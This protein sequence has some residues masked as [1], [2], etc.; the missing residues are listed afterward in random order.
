MKAVLHALLLPALPLFPQAAPSLPERLDAEFRVEVEKGKPKAAS[1]SDRL[2]AEF[3]LPIHLNLGEAVLV[4][5]NKSPAAPLALEISFA[6]ETT[7][8]VPAPP[9]RVTLAAG[10]PRAEHVVRI[11]GRPDGQYRTRIREIPAPGATAARPLVRTLIKQTLPEP[12]PPENPRDVRGTRLLF[13]DDWLLASRAGTVRRVHPP[14]LFPVVPWKNHPDLARFPRNTIS[15]FHVDADGA[16]NVRVTAARASRGN[17]MANAQTTRYWLKSADLR[18]WEPVK[19]PAPPHPGATFANSPLHLSAPPL[20][21]GAVCR[22]H[23]PALDGPP[24]IAQVRVYYTGLL[25]ETLD[26]AGFKVPGRRVVSVWDKTPGLRL[27]LKNPVTEIPSNKNGVP[28]KND[29]SSVND[30]FGRPLLSADGKTLRF[31]QTRRVPR[32]AP[33]RVHYD[34]L[35]SARIQVTWSSDDGIHWTPAAFAP[36]GPGDSPFLQHYDMRVWR[37]ENGALEMAYLQIYDARLQQISTELVCSRDGVLWRRVDP[38]N[39]FLK[40][41]APGEW[42]FGFSRPT[43]N[44][45]R[46]A[47]G[48]HYYETMHGVDALHFMALVAAPVAD[49]S[50][51]PDDIYRTRYGGRMAGPDGLP[52]SPI[53][54]WYGSWDALLNATRGERSTPALFRYR[55]DRWASLSPENRTA[56]VLTKPLSAPGQTLALN[57]LAAAGEIRVEVRDAGGSPLP[58]YS[59]PDAARFSGDATAAPLRWSGG[60]VSRLPGHPF[61]LAIHLRNASLFALEFAP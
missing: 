8:R 53:W 10:A 45:R 15:D 4:L 25:H 30:N 26:W 44:R 39:P 14:E 61:T 58:G 57:A 5:E 23:D 46:M 24:D 60:A 32:H 55:R 1:L 19:K 6:E 20:P 54:K 22:P 59:G 51:I 13:L 52:S 42:N 21:P 9:A 49:R 17:D 36:P 11:A 31:W 33:F 18:D 12:P 35:F 16:M 34:N 41:G 29:W 7:R 43:A 2:A 27:V 37:E 56:T 40:N 47:F 3:S 48:D 50:T 28:E 38:G